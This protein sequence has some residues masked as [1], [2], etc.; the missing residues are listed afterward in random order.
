MAIQDDN[1]VLCKGDLKAYHEQI[2]PYLGGNLMLGTNISDYYSTDEKIVGVWTDGKPVYQKV[3]NIG[4]LTKVTTKTEL[5][6][7]VGA[8]VDRYIEFSSSLTNADNTWVGQLEWSSYTPSTAIF[9][10]A[11]AGGYNNSAS[12]ANKK[13]KIGVVYDGTCDW[14]KNVI[15]VAKYTKTT[16][17]ANSA[18]S[19]PGCYDINRP[20]LWPANKEI[21]FGNGL[22][23]YRATGNM[24]ALSVGTDWTNIK[25]LGNIGT[26]GKTYQAGGGF[27]T[28]N[29]NNV[30]AWTQLGFSRSGSF[31]STL[32]VSTAGD[33]QIAVKF[34]TGGHHS[35]TTNKYDVWVTYTK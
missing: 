19:T 31:E 4:N 29:S 11:L 28:M 18:V 2:L 23:G 32:V 5:L 6:V 12:D 8:S 35:A 7:P 22:Y 21:F 27:E 13:N 26:S 9:T 17:A 10:Y 33:L 30:R 24:P 20:D 25:A 34:P 3:F 15:I 16:D 1:T 14:I